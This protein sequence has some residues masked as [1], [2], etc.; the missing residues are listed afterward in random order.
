M[1]YKQSDIKV[2][3]KIK[4]LDTERFKKK[5][6][7]IVV[8]DSVLSDYTF[9]CKYL[10]NEDPFRVGTVLDI[11]FDVNEEGKVFKILQNKVN[12]LPTWL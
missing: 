2:G 10:V 9:L 4:I 3:T 12:H 8:V 7:G 1:K 5:H 6:H 11:F